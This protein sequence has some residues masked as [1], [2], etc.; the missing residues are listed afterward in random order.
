VKSSGIAVQLK[1]NN[2]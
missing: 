1:L 2:S